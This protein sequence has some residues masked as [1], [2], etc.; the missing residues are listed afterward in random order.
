MIRFWIEEFLQISQ[1]D[2]MQRKVIALHYSG[3]PKSKI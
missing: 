2:V 3:N 1:S